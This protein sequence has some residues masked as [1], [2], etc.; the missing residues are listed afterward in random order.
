M[1]KVFLITFS[2]LIVCF[3]SGLTWATGD[4]VFRSGVQFVSPTGE[5]KELDES[6][7][8]DSAVG[9]SSGYEHV[10]MD[11]IGIDFN[12]AYSNHDLEFS[13]P[14]LTQEVGEINS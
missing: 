6:L 5:L 2:V 1:K 10:F 8:A 3:F 11:R 7:E 9:F 13:E 12:I 14:G 4:N